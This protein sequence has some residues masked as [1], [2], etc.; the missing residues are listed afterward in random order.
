MKRM[1]LTL[2]VL[3]TTAM[4]T[5]AQDSE[6]RAINRAEA[7][8][9]QFCEVPQG[10]ELVSYTAPYMACDYRLNNNPNT[11]GYIVY[12][13]AKPNCPP[14]QLCIQVIYPVATITVNCDL[15]VDSIICGVAGI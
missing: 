11:M 9:R 4:T 5:F 8:A 1:L 14:N 3:L 12:V 10:Y 7:A 15:S 6:Q 13:S 2:T